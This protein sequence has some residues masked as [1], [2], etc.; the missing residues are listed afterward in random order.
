V[1]TPKTFG[2]EKRED[3]LVFFIRGL[4]F[5]FCEWMKNEV[6]MPKNFGVIMFSIGVR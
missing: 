5:V 3:D 6:W 4:V 1:W 2:V